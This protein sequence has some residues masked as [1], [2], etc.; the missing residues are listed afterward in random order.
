MTERKVIKVKKQAIRRVRLKKVGTIAAMLPL[1]MS[2]G[3]PVATLI[4]GRHGE[5]TVGIEQVV[6][7][8]EQE[9]SDVVLPETPAEEVV[10]GKESEDTIER[11]FKEAP[12]PFE[13]PQKFEEPRFFEGGLTRFE[14]SAITPLNVEWNDWENR[15]NWS[16]G[17]IYSIQWI[18]E[19]AV[20]IE[21]SRNFPDVN[22][23]SNTFNIGVGQF[24]GIEFK[25]GDSTGLSEVVIAGNY[26]HGGADRSYVTL[27]GISPE[28]YGQVSIYGRNTGKAEESIRI[29]GGVLRPNPFVPI[30]LAEEHILLGTV[31]DKFIHDDVVAE[32]VQWPSL[33]LTRLGFRG[34][35]DFIDKIEN[36]VFAS[37]DSAGPSQIN[38]GDI[39]WEAIRE[40]IVSELNRQRTLEGQE[41]DIDIEA[42][43][44]SFAGS[45]LFKQAQVRENIP[46]SL[47]NIV[48]NRGLV[49][50]RPFDTT[51]AVQR[52]EEHI[53]LDFEIEMANGDR[54]SLPELLYVQLPV[55]SLLH[56]QAGLWA[57]FVHLEGNGAQRA[58]VQEAVVQA[59]AEGILPEELSVDLLEQL[60]D[61]IIAQSMVRNQPNANGLYDGQITLA[62]A[63]FTPTTIGQLQ[64]VPNKVF[65]NNN[66]IVD[67]EDEY[68]FEFAIMGDSPGGERRFAI[69][70][71]II[72]REYLNFANNHVGTHKII[73]SPYIYKDFIFSADRDDD[74]FSAEDLKLFEEEY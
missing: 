48:V 30:V 21:F 51:R 63:S 45:G 31:R 23:P 24:S 33:D 66:I 43:Q 56:D 29:I 60:T 36:I 20:R 18:A 49:E 32:V 47:R 14:G 55:T 41:Y 50:T 44:E 4:R 13:A 40:V 46:V 8:S 11:S 70:T 54:V 64:S 73:I 38:Y 17:T 1:V 22:R 67:G 53:S 6:E 72:D 5:E 59:V 62:D 16:I 74:A 69:A 35:L 57:S 61:S 19:D 3:A 58:T 10:E 28:T 26:S 7:L 27:W 65:D 25:V 52:I 9:I 71:L 39:D 12:T 34:T 42:L 2:K 37:T 68:V 15:D